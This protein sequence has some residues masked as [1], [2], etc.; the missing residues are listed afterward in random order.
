[1]TK[2]VSYENA[3]RQGF[4]LVTE[5]GVVAL[6]DRGVGATSLQ[7]LIVQGADLRR[8][9]D[10]FGGRPADVALD[11]L[12]Y[13][14]PVHAP[15]KIVCVGLNYHGHMTETGRQPVTHPTL[16]S[17]W[18][19]SHVGH[20]EPLILPS[21]SKKFDYEGELAI[22]IGRQGRHV[23]RSEAMAYVV[24][25]SCYNDGS[26]RD[27]QKHTS[28]FLPGKN[29]EASGAFGPWLV[30]AHSVPDYRELRLTTRLNGQIVQETNL[31]DM[32]FDIPALIEYVSSFTTLNP[33]DVLVTGTPDG[34][35]AFRDPQLWM[36]AGDTVD[37][38][39]S[40]VG[41]LSNTVLAETD[42]VART[43]TMQRAEPSQ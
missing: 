7:E 38:E 43:A 30:A 11:E 33:G 34:V 21:V 13:L 27:W 42:V 26:I 37:V 39:I 8:I 9:E 35:G 3:S 41:V 18:P 25:Y 28:Q 19:D 29:F 22:V 31:A 24:G 36:A 16:F 20:G 12:R 4:G 2:L 32:I 17:R 5:S 40:G 6:A 23:P 1:M 15:Q 14:P 10:K